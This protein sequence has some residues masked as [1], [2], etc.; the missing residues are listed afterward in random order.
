MIREQ[1]VFGAW[2]LYAKAHTWKE[3][4]ESVWWHVNQLCVAVA[5]T[6]DNKQK[7]EEIFIPIEDC[8]TLLVWACGSMTYTSMSVWWCWPHGD[9]EEQDRKRLPSS[10][11]IPEHLSSNLLPFTRPHLLNIVTNSQTALPESGTTYLVRKKA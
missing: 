11:A 3:D 4:V 9:H 1:L 7:K 6:R 10:S 8:L 2:I 5:G